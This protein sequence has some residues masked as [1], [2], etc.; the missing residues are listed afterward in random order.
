MI[1][2]LM[3]LTILAFLFLQVQDQLEDLLVSRGDVI[4]LQHDAGPSALI[5]CQSSPHSLWRQP[6]LAINRSEWFWINKPPADASIDADMMPDPELDLKAVLDDG[7]GGWMENVV[8][9]IRVLY[10]GH[11]E[12]PL[13]GAQ[14]SAGLPQPGIYSLLVRYQS[15]VTAQHVSDS[16]LHIQVYILDIWPMLTQIVG[17]DIGGNG[18]NQGG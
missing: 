4:A 15:C 12:I 13:Q 3:S 6:V 11:S 5:H 1:G 7:K 2:L 17:L 14:L 10:V 8:C 18:V 9:P 16:A